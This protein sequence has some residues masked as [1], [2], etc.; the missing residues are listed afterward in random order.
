[1][2]K[3]RSIGRSKPRRNPKKIC[4]LCGNKIVNSYRSARYCIECRRKQ[5]DIKNRFNG[6]SFHM[7]KKYP[8]FNINFRLTIT[9]KIV[10]DKHGN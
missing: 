5:H 2:R 6:V 1:M 8:D 9:K 3:A 7:R 10:E 4:Y